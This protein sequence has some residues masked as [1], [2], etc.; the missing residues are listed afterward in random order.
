MP[1]STAEIIGLAVSTTILLLFLLRVQSTERRKL[2]SIGGWFGLSLSFLLLGAISDVAGRTGM[3]EFLRGLSVLFQGA[4]LIR[5][6]GVSV[7]VVAAPVVQLQFSRL[8]QEVVVASAMAAWTVAW[9]RGVHDVNLA[10][11]V[12]PSAVATAILG[13]SLQDTLGNILG[14]MALQFEESVR[15][16]DWI[17]VDDLVGRV[18]ETHWRY[19]AVETRN[20]E[21]VVIP[22]SQ[23][24]KN[25]FVVL[26]RRQQRAVQLRRW[27]WFNIDYRYSPQ[28]VMDAVLPAIQNAD[29][30][31]MARDPKPSCV[32]MDFTDSYSKFAIRYWLTDLFVDDPTDSEVRA[33]VFAALARNGI[34][35][36]V[37]AHAIFLTK[38]TNRRKKRKSE[39]A[40]HERVALVQ[41]L[42]LFK[43]LT[44]EE[45]LEVAKRLKATP[46]F[47]GDVM[48]RQGAQAHWLYIIIDGT[49]DVQVE[50]PDG[51]IAKISTMGAGSV[52]GEMGLL[53]GAPRSA[54]VIARS[55]VECYRLDRDSFRDILM[56]RPA[57]A[58]ELSAIMQKR[59]EE[60]EAVLHSVDAHAGDPHKTA[61]H[62]FIKRIRDFFNLSA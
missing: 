2:L 59:S 17:K 57:L 19:T 16:D 6:L 60:Q 34:P 29:I 62:E 26:G 22:N 43:T 50:R 45:A 36:S 30:P 49:A 38:E 35:L 41:K 56:S 33:H 8:F 1:K 13:L 32:L 14:G 39:Q 40:I 55:P 3:A 42:D 61:G 53:T 4:C 25:K 37:P 27:I 5:L 31:N 7:F 21:T 10:T 24:L 48:T 54:T 46:F 44:P 18:S 12:A 28:Q 47:R 20:W 51:S 58:G 23:L 52:F 11:L 15:V 9:L